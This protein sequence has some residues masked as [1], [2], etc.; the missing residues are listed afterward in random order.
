VTQPR[1]LIG[2]VSLCDLAILAQSTPAGHPLVEVGVY[3]GGSA[4]YLAKVATERGDELHLF[5][6]FT[7][8]PL[9]DANDSHLTGD[10]DDT[11]LEAVQQAVP[12]AHFHVGIFPAT[13]PPSI[14]SVAFVHC[15]CDQYRSVRAV[16]DTFW[17]MLVPG[18][19]IAFD[20]MDTAGGQRAILETFP[21]I[22]QELGWWCVRKPA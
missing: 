9:H 16:I 5:D 22:G 18:G 8:I 7:G 13:M 6:T 3:Q 17:P 15:D 2:S 11:S 20:D 12:S 4:W 10:F 14:T 1:S 21:G 19:V